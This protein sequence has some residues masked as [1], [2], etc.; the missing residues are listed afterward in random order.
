MLPTFS[1]LQV[2]KRGEVIQVKVLGTVALIDEGET[3]WKI[4]A[5]DV[6]DPLAP[7][8]NGN[9]K[10]AWLSQVV[11]T[12]SCISSQRNENYISFP[13]TLYVNKFRS[14]V[15]GDVRVSTPFK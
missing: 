7:Q 5:I 15:N 9:L 1:F 2:A 8:L 10:I 13:V 11:D 6:N 3:D 14:Q 12:V 4:I